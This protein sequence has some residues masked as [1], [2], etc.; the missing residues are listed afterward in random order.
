MLYLS[1]DA[2]RY[3]ITTRLQVRQQY[4]GK[5]LAMPLEAYYFYYFNRKGKIDHLNFNKL[6]DDCM[7]QLLWVDDSQILISHHYTLYDKETP[8]IELCVKPII[9]LD[10]QHLV[11]KI[12]S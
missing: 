11:K 4:K 9:N 12:W 1:E 2:K 8:R 5:P 3:S 6:F 10:I 7:N